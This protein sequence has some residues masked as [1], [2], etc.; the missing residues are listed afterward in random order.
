MFTTCLALCIL[1]SIYH[2]MPNLHD[3][4]AVN[5]RGNFFSLQNE[6]FSEEPYTLLHSPQGKLLFTLLG[7]EEEI[8]H[9]WLIGI[10]AYTQICPT[11]GRRQLLCLLSPRE[12]SV[13]Q[14]HP[15]R[16]TYSFQC[17]LFLVSVF[18]LKI[19][20]LETYHLEEIA[21]SSAIPF[22]VKQHF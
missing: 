10:L 16:Q 9:N 14:V 13:E 15:Q 17:C 18:T 8:R 19:K 1:V 4:L 2:L 21:F 3:N 11:K 12:S 22:I 7:C 6:W 20:D 5:A